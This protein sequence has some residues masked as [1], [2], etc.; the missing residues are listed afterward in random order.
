MSILQCGRFQLGLERPLVMGIVN[1]TPD[2]F[3]DGGRHA[4]T[5]AAIAHARRL[6]ADGADMLDIGGE[7]TRP[8]AAFVPADE[9]MARVLPVLAALQPLG[10]PLSIDTRKPAVMHAALQ[11]GV[12]LVN[13]ITALE[14]QGALAML[15]QSPAAV[16]LMHMQGEPQ[17]MQAAPQ[18]DDVVAEVTAYLAARRNAALAA[19]IASDRIVLD[20]GFGFGK[21][22]AHNA[23]L[24]RALPATI[25]QLGCP[26]LIGVSRK[27]MLGDITG[28]PV[29]ARLPASIAAALLAAQAGAAILRVHDVKETVDALKVLRALQ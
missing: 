27:R 6:V 15:A 14:G 23:A 13:D 10:V 12:D 8:G 3:S 29:E 20:P 28:Q 18:Y 1:I 5:A 7:S 26:Q 22:L 2:S 21:N 9:E 17:T 25:A 16:C 11:A 24:F 19:G 4:T